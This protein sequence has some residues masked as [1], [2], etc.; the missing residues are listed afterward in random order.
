MVSGA[1]VVDADG[2]PVLLDQLVQAV[3]AVRGGV[4]REVAD[5]ECFREVEDLAGGR[6]ILAEMDHAV[7]ADVDALGLDLP[8]QRL[9]RL[10][11][12][13]HRDVQGVRLPV[14]DAQVLRD[15][16]GLLQ[17]RLAVRGVPPQG[18]T[19]EAQLE[20]PGVVLFPGRGGRRPVT[21]RLRK[22]TPRWSVRS[23]GRRDASAYGRR[24]SWASG[25]SSEQMDRSR[26][27]DS[28]ANPWPGDMPEATRIRAGGSSAETAPSH[29]R[30]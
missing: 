3:E 29:L 21:G 15:G 1:V 17:V 14:V 28:E 7:A 24:N 12:G 16:Q 8:P 9:D 11:V 26:G 27:Q 10:G 30:G 25:S 22:G 5:S 13:G 4:G 23:S 2:D 6:L 19:L 18:V 20:R